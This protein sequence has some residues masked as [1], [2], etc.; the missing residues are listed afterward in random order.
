MSLPYEGEEQA[1]NVAGDLLES[2]PADEYPS[3]YELI[4]GHALQPGYD[5]AAEFEWGL[6]LILDALEQRSRGE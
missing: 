5:Y 3:L 2:F 1:H 6:D 4:V